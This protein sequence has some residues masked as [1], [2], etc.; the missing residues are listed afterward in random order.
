MQESFL[1]DLLYDPAAA[2]NY[3]ENMTL[4]C[5]V[6]V[7]K[8]LYSSTPE[9]KEFS[10]KYKNKYELTQ[11]QKEALI[12]IPPLLF[13]CIPRLYV[14]ATHRGISQVQRRFINMEKSCENKPDKE[15]DLK[16]LHSKYIKELF[17]DRIAPVKPFDVKPIATCTNFLDKALRRQFFKEW[18]SNSGIYLIE[19]KHD[20]SIYPIFSRQLIRLYSTKVVQCI[21]SGFIMASTPLSLGKIHP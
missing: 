4:I 21:Q 16:S 1:L 19:Y 13:L 17:R 9:V 11:E 12:G 3:I 7:S 8:R 15:S 2:H 6:C 20:R 5:S 14:G 18:G 10:V